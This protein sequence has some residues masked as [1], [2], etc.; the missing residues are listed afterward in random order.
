VTIVFGGYGKRFVIFQSYFL[1][2]PCYETELPLLR[3][4]Q[5]RDTKNQAKQSREKKKRAGKKH[6][7]M[8]PDGFF[9][10]NLSCF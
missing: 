5:K 8:S 4:G 2:S 1:N 7:F 9:L 3:N 6:F 10:N